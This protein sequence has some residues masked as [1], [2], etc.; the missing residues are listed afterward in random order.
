[1]CKYLGNSRS[2]W[3]SQQ[4]KSVLS[5]SFK[6]NTTDVT[7]GAEKASLA[8]PSGAP[9]IISSSLFQSL[10]SGVCIV[11]S[12]VFRVVLYGTLFVLLP[13]FFL[14]IALSVLRF[15]C[16]YFLLSTFNLFFV[17]PLSFLSAVEF[18]TSV[19]API[20]VPT[21]GLCSPYVFFETMWV[22]YC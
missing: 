8:N 11:Q 13:F 15:M 19:Q 14:I 2:C 22:R 17:Y 20:T 21:F 18:K 9:D 5:C 3:R 16:Y 10:F 1:M 7:S 12:L 4:R 6:S